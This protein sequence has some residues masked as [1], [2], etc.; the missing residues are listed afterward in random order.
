[1]QAGL[2]RGMAGIPLSTKFASERQSKGHLPA[3]PAH[4]ERIPSLVIGR[5]GEHHV[6]GRWQPAFC[7]RLPLEP[8]PRVSMPSESGR[9]S[10]IA[11]SPR[12][13]A[14]VCLVRSTL[15]DHAQSGSIPSSGACRTARIRIVRRRPCE[16]LRPTRMIPS[17]SL[18]DTSASR[19]ARR[20]V[21]PVRSCSG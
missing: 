6:R 15:R 11:P 4:V 17:R 21:L 18:A 1:M 10:T 3:H 8:P 16:W 2:A 9:T 12:D 13:S 5:R 20:T 19:S 7:V 14:E